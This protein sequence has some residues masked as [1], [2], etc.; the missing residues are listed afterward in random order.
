MKFP[1]NTLAV[2]RPASIRQVELPRRQQYH[3]SPSD[4]R[5]EIIYFL[6]PD[7]FSDGQEA[8][9][10]LLDRTDRSAHRPAYFR[11]DA[12]AE[13]GSGRY[14][15]GTIKGIT[16]KLDYLHQ[17][18]ATTLW[19]APVFKQ[20]T[21]WDSY[22]GYAI[23]DFLEVDPRL[24]TRAD[25]CDLVAGAHQ[26]GM[27]VLL[28]IV[29][30]HTSQNW[31]YANA[32]REDQPPY[33]PWPQY[34]QKGPWLDGQGGKTSIIQTD[35]DGVWPVELTPDEYY[36]RAGEGRL[37]VGDI[38]DSNA[39]YRRTDFI[40]DRDINYDHPGV[41]DDMAR[42]YKYW[43]SLTDCDGFR[44]DT[45]KHMP[46]E[47]G[48]NLCGTIKEFAAGLGKADF[49][50]VGE[51]AGSDA[52]ADRYID[53]LSSN[54]NAAT[55]IGESRVNL[56]LV[57][58]GLL[59]P[60]SYF[61]IIASWDDELGSHRDSGRRHVSILDDHD[62]VSGEKV[63]FCSD[64]T[65]E[66]HAGVVGVAIQLFSLGIPCIYYGTEQAFA[67][68]EKSERD[69]YLPDYNKSINNQSVPDRYL[70]EAMFG[71]EHPR[72]AGLAGLMPGVA[73]QD[74]TLPGFGPFGTC[75]A[76][77]FDDQS[78]SYVRIQALIKVRAQFPALRYGRQY[79]RPISN[80]GAPFALGGAGELVTWSRILDDEEVLCVVNANGGAARGADVLVDTSL[81]A[82]SSAGSPWGENAPYFQVIANSAQAAALA[83]GHPYLGTHPI[84]SQLPL[85][86][87]GALSFVALR[88]VQPAEVLI[89]TNRP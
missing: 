11:W 10:P 84:G 22:H 86:S 26:R 71:P 85:Q 81:N 18:G 63:R 20:R 23:Q 30:N 28:D 64:A 44:I 87:S 42:C 69:Q 54:L 33:L 25:L 38:D 6:L 88:E 16:S 12:W 37:D 51:V 35:D 52:D 45:L 50:L 82:A 24:G 55:D 62:C 78:A 46:E 66:D 7:R 31:W 39:E 2:K 3:P 67:G 29:F 14:Q 60:E 48:R 61:K 41:L 19:V 4:W 80:F 1:I 13:G 47:V 53:V 76:H 74:T 17:L 59:P 43:I 34:Y 9:R 58:R 70:R 72:L 21:H 77:C 57:A 8:G 56:H 36:T 65:P 40:G 15:G 32:P 49:F 73:G 79:Q 83:A 68:P 5:D 89:L 75:G 27:R